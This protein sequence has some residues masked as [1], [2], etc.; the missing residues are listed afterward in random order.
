MCRSGGNFGIAGKLPFEGTYTGN[1]HYISS[2]FRHTSKNFEGGLPKT[3]FR[4]KHCFL[5]KR[6]EIWVFD[7][8]NMLLLNEACVK[9]A[10]SL[11]TLFAHSCETLKN[12]SHGYMIT[13]SPEP[14]TVGL[15]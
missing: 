8:I 1:H 2:E 3:Y 12:I 4:E 14:C 10:V 9:K 13:D 11:I 6:V 15:R 5:K 7:G